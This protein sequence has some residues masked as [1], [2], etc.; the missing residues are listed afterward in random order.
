M[1]SEWFLE[2]KKADFAGIA[3]RFGIDQVTARI[4]RNR[5]IVT[6]EQI[7]M[8]LHGEEDRLYEPRLMMNAEKAAGMIAGAIRDRVHIRIIGDYDVDGVCSAYILLTSIKRCGGIADAAIPHRVRDGYGINETLID[9]A[10][11][12]G[13]GMI[14]TCDNGIAAYDQIAYAEEQGIKVVVTDHH[15]VPHVTDDDGM[16]KWVIPP[17]DAVV[18]PHQAGDAYPYKPVCGAVVA[19]KVSRI[20]MEMLCPDTAAAVSH[21][22]MGEAALATVCDVMPLLDENR[23]I[24][25]KGLEILEEGGSNIGL[26]AL[27]RACGLSGR[28]ITSYSAGFVI[29]PCINASG[30]LATAEIALSLLCADDTGDAEKIAGELVELNNVRKAD[31]EEMTAGAF[32]LIEEKGLSGRDVMVVYLPECSESIA[33]IIAG[34]IRERYEHPVFVVTRSEDGLKGSGRSTEAFDMYAHM[35]RHPELFSRFGGHKAA[36]GFSMEEDRLELFEKLI[37]EDTGLSEEDFI[38]KVRIDVPMPVAYLTPG[39]IDELGKLEPFGNGNPRPLFAQKDV[40]ILSRRSVGR[41]GEY[42]K[43]RI[44]TGNGR[45]TDMMFFGDAGSFNEYLDSHDNSVSIVYYPEI[46]EFRG[47][48]SIQII[49]TD[50]R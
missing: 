44:G 8:F 45:A 7:S 33:G 46:N 34:R 24:V 30:R 41:N 22:L 6:D 3:A 9:D 14:V 5:D 40:K 18:D 42:G 49:L 25:K 31:T 29:G 36:A 13:A 38:R 27:I 11:E 32:D 28:P 17:A 35:N 12:S 47:V 21:M 19:W 37:N 43:Y 2:T 15:E 1:D 20:L 10:A 50:Y 39:L 48:R 16:V 4:L 23:I 26:D